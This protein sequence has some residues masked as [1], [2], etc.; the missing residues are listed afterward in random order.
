MVCMWECA[1]G[2]MGKT[3]SPITQDPLCPEDALARCLGKS[4][5]TFSKVFYE[6]LTGT[7]KGETF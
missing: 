4:P 2:M 6:V 1:L 5:S 7:V 3:L